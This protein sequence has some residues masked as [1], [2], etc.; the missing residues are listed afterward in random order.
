MPT[1]FFAMMFIKV[2]GSKI[3]YFFNVYL[4][5]CF[6]LILFVCCFLVLVLVNSQIT[7]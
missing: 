3:S 4:K 5:Q 1:I 2:F 7:L 6:Q